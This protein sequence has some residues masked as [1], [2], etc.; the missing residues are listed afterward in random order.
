M[1]TLWKRINRVIRHSWLDESDLQRAMSPVMLDRLQQKIEFSEQ[2]HSGEIRICIEASLPWLTLRRNVPVGQSVRARAL[3]LFSEMGVW[4]TAN[5][6]GVLIYVL[7]ADHAIE[8]IADRGIN[9]CVTPEHWLS[10]VAQIGEEFLEGK[11]EQ[12]LVQGIDSVSET[13]RTHFPTD[14][15]QNNPN[16][17]PDRPALR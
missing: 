16:E 13:L 17:L 1:V 15:R 2:Q 14:G 11:F 10:L 5:N 4:D 9:A 8:I 6:N 3:T 12:G 7:L